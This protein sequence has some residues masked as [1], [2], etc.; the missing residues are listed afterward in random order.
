MHS[1]F[2]YTASYIA[3]FTTTASTHSCLY[4]ANCKKAGYI[5]YTVSKNIHIVTILLILLC[6]YT[7]LQY[8]YLYMQCDRSFCGDIK[9]PLPSEKATNSKIGRGG[10]G[11]VFII[12]HGKKEYAVKQVFI[13]LYTYA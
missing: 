9:Y 11:F 10:N 6:M 5:I 7:C 8:G 1:D 4:E 12:Y 2:N 3:N 13:Y